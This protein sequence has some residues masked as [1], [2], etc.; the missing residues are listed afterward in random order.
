MFKVIFLALVP[1]LLISCKST[2]EF[3]GFSYD[4][5]GVTDTATRATEA[6]KKRIIGAGNPKVW[7]SN[8]F[9]SARMNDFYQVNDSTFEVLIKPENAPI[10]NSPWYAFEIWSETARR[11]H[12]RIAYQDARHRYTPKLTNGFETE[13][14]EPVLFD[15]TTGTAEFVFEVTPSRQ[16]I[17]GQSL[18]SARFSDLTRYLASLSQPFITVDTAGFSHN[19]NPILEITADETEPDKPAGVLI[20]LSRQHPPEIPGYLTFRVFLEALLD[21][22]ELASTFREHFVIKAFPIVNPDGVIN[23]HWRHNTGGIDLNRDW[24]FF[25]QPETRA[26]RDALLPLAGNPMRKVYY[27]IDFHSTNENIFYPIN[28]GVVTFPDNFTQRWVEVIKLDNPDIRFR[29][30]EFDT[31]SPISKNWIFKTFGADAVTFEVDDAL[32]R[33]QIRELGRSSAISLMQMLLEDLN[34]SANH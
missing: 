33:D 18:L 23:G 9:E 6:Q 1:I 3:T 21:T 19:A 11:I 16:K 8:E 26:I 2:S 30:E 20:I 5:P 31:S 14:I 28:E 22:T 17:T 25:N 15:T 4:P 34:N 10:N 24:E 32:S 27:G 29:S 12:L 7:V 13:I